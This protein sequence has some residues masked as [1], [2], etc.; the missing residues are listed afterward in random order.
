VFVK[1]IAEGGSAF[2]YQDK[3]L[4]AKL[5][6]VSGIDVTT[7]TFD[8]V[9]ELIGDAPDTVELELFV[10]EPEVKV[11]RKRYK[12]GTTVTINL[13]QEGKPDTVIKAT[14]GANLRQTMLDNGVEVYQGMKQKLGNCGG[15]GQ[16]TFCAVDFIESEGW[17]ERSDYEDKKLKKNPDARLACI[18]EIQ[19]PATIRKAKR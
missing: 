4:G 1:D 7:L 3:I 15:Q 11:K 16:C 18:N 5:S 2:E 9:M 6:T 17:L 10:K 19:G 8:S 12:E 14:V 13:L